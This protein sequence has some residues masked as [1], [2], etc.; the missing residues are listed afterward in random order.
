MIHSVRGINTRPPRG[1]R[2]NRSHPLS[3]GLMFAWVFNELTGENAF[4]HVGHKFSP[5]MGT[6][7][8]ERGGVLIDNSLERIQ[9]PNAGLLKSKGTIIQGYRVTKTPGSYYRYF[10]VTDDTYTE[11]ALYQTVDSR[12]RFYLN[13]NTCDYNG[14]LNNND[15]QPHTMTVTW[16][17][18]V[19]Q[20]QIFNDATK[21]SLVDSSFTWD[22]AGMSAY[23][24]L[25][26][27]R[28]T[29][30]ARH[31]G[32]I[33]YYT[34]IFDRVLP[35]HE[36]IA[37]QQNPYQIFEHSSR[38]RYYGLGNKVVADDTDF[39]LSSDST[40]AISSVSFTPDDSLYALSSDSPTNVVPNLL[41]VVDN[42]NY[43]MI[44]V[45]PFVGNMDSLKTFTA[46]DMISVFTVK[47]MQTVFT[48]KDMI[49]EFKIKNS[50]N[51]AFT[52][53]GRR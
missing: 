22:N 5:L 24:L 31:I 38:A 1:S 44:S 29:G 4:E 34:Y 42:T 21:L 15:G 6:T 37:F 36:I 45:S 18:A 10:F 7:G 48:V 3:K 46:M 14:A 53:G 35:D 9:G 26:G 27:G 33:L 11:F 41:I 43:A 23:N 47:D 25:I 12:L 49:N 17:D 2:L 30:T 13:N 28:L 16:D 51:M 50:E 39:Q 52:I 19:P 8:Y 32:G 40:T 20:R